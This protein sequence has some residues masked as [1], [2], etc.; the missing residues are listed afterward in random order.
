MKLERV[1]KLNLGLSASA[2]AASFALATPHFATSLALG[3]FLEAI[4]FGALYRGAERFFAGEFSGAG[5]W[6]GLF[7]TRFVL[8]AVG[9]FVTLSAGAHPVALLIGL[10]MAMPAVLID[11][12]RRRPPVLDP[13]TL[14]AQGPDDPSWDRY[15]IWQAGEVAPQRDDDACDEDEEGE[16]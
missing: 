12:I 1:E 5:P 7:A 13:E 2:V 6:V 9:I 16:R 15:S 3:A 8:L 4:N 14:P 11:A 10:S